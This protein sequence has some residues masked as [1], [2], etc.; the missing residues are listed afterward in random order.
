MSDAT[1]RPSIPKLSRESR[2]LFIGDSITDAGRGADKE[3]Q[4]GNGYVRLVRDLLRA[5]DPANAPHVINRG[6][7]GNK[8]TDLSAR[9]ERDVIAS[10]PHLLSVMIGINDVWHGLNPAWAPGVDIDDY[11]AIYRDLLT[12]TRKGLPNCRVVLMEPTVID[13]PA[14]A[15]GNEKLQPYVK[16]VNALAKEFAGTVVAAVPTH[17]AF[18]NARTARP[19]IVWAPDGVHP[20]TSGHMLIA[21]TWLAATG[22]L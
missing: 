17:T 2:V 11:T 8:V 18:V 6:I 12:R 10:D 13:P 15:E 5:K 20:S 9:W 16:A 1:T 4:I 22:L 7:S 19:D 21:R 14:P 3:E